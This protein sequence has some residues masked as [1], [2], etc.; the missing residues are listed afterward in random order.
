MPIRW[1]VSAAARALGYTQPA[2]S[3]L[4]D[5]S[6]AI[7]HPEHPAAAGDPPLAL[8]LTRAAGF[9]PDIAYATDD[10]VTVQSLVAAEL[11]VTLQPA[12]ALVAARRDD[13]VVRRPPAVLAMLA[14]LCEASAALA[15]TPEA[16]ALGIRV[17]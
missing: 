1:E 15:A 9:T 3:L 4:H 17:A 5:P 12:L 10:Y 8:H 16:A 7:V 13:V 2:V 6:H 11:G 14:A